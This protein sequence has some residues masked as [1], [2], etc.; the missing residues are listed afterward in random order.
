MMPDDE[1]STVRKL[2]PLLAAASLFGVLITVFFLSPRDV[3][4]PAREVIGHSVEGRP[5]E[6]W[7]F[8]HGSRAVLFMASIHGSEGAGTPLLEKLIALFPARPAVLDGTKVIVLPVANP[9]GMHRGRRLNAR[10]VDLNRNFP[11]ENRRDT[12]RYGSENAPEPETR[13]LLALLER[14][15][16]EVIVSIHQPLQC[17]DYDGP[18]EAMDLAVRMARA[19]GLPVRK[20][21]AR[22]GSLGAW[23]G[24]DLQR[25]VLTMELPAYVPRDPDTLWQVYGS[26]LLDVISAMDPVGGRGAEQR[27]RGL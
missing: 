3:V 11:A 6:C 21:G 12:G 18:P 19:C 1:F 26:S 20:L 15:R 14:H 23:Y 22:P 4:G 27:S 13:A 5:I 25:I 9:D 16:P 24:D 8:G 17:I 7:T 10:D 2:A